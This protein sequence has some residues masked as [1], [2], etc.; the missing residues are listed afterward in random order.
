ML[1]PVRRTCPFHPLSADSRRRFFRVRCSAI[2]PVNRVLCKYLKKNCQVQ[3][4]CAISEAVRGWERICSG[5]GLSIHGTSQRQRRT[6]S[7]QAAAG[8]SP[9][10]EK[11]LPRPRLPGEDE[12]GGGPRYDR[13]TGATG[14]H[15]EI[16]R[17]PP[18]PASRNY[19][20]RHG[21]LGCAAGPDGRDRGCIRIL[22]GDYALLR[23]APAVRGPVQP[24]HHDP[25]RGRKAGRASSPKSRAGRG[26][27]ITR[28]SRAWR[29]SRKAVW[30]TFKARGPRNEDRGTE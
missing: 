21:R 8:R 27:A 14:C 10:R 9:R 19:P 17:D 20:Q 6:G 25:R 4:D 7:P 24:L 29:S 13:D 12:R 22:Q 23:K 5:G 15:P 28:C 3:F 18:A 2:G 26:S 11:T 30:N 1:T 16:R